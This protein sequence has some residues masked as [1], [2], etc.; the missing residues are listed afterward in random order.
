MLNQLLHK[1]ITYETILV[2]LV[3]LLFGIGTGFLGSL[4]MKFQIALC[5]GL[6]GMVAMALVPHK[7][8]LCLFLVILIQPLS[9]EKIIYTAPGILSELRGLEIVLNAAD[10]VLIA[11]GLLVFVESFQQRKNL[12]YW[13]KKATL[14]LALI[15]WAAISYLIHLLFFQTGFV[16]SAKLGLLHMSRN[17]LFVVIITS[18]IRT[19]ADLIWVLIGVLVNI[20]LQ[21]ALVT[22]SFFTHETYTFMRLLGGPTLS[23]TYAGSGDVVTRAVGTVGVA[24][25]QGL[26]HAMFTFL[27]IGFFGVKNQTFKNLAL[28][29]ILASFLGVIF[30]FSRGAWLSMILATILIVSI[31]IKRREITPKSWLIGSLVMMVFVL[32]MSA[33]IQPII[34]RLTKGDDGAT[35]SRIRMIELA[36]D[37]W[38]EYPIIGVGPSEYVEAGLKLYPPGYRANEWVG[39]GNKAIVPPLGRIE[40]ARAYIP[41]YP[42]IIVPLSVHN[43]YLLTLCELGIVG[44]VL[45]LMIFYEFY[46]DARV[47]SKAQDPFFRFLGVGGLGIVLVAVVYMNVD[48]FADDKT[49]QILL[50]PLVIISAASK[51]YKQ[52]QV[53]QRKNLR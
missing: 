5:V 51:L 28:L 40:L 14:F 10:L 16:S 11:L 21:S 52:T 47:C 48:L 1:R 22:L 3:S 31:F 2:V 30:T 33:V 6:F 4:A 26:F 13:D 42:E 39:L 24:N 29:A 36:Y 45:W 25:Q 20:L 9:I 34:D 35:G 27:L 8:A 23:Q 43:K 49:L 32:A 46:K 12:F 17:L 50:F 38:K 19:R 44:L 41:G 53:D 37:L 7:R 15:V 18:A